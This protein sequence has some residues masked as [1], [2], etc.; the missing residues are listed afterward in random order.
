MIPHSP[1]AAQ[2][3]AKFAHK[4]NMTRLHKR[5]EAYLLKQL[6][7]T[8]KSVF[9]WASLAE[10]LELSLLL[11]HCEQ[12]IILNFHVMSAYEKQVSKISQSSLLRIMDGLA[13]RD[14]GD[15]DLT[16]S[17]SGAKLCV[18]EACGVLYVGTA[19]SAIS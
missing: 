3:L 16:K 8:T 15:V 14:V 18:R 17:C 11:A 2:V 7:L 1:S 6:Q 9:G 19:V 13:G 12:Y 10:R 4:Y 5:S